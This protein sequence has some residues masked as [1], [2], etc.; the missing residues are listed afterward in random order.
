[1]KLLSI[2][3]VSL[4][5]CEVSQAANTTKLVHRTVRL[6]APS[7]SGDGGIYAS[8]F[9]ID[10]ETI[11]TAGH[12]CEA[13]QESSGKISEK[14]QVNFINANDEISVLDGG[15]I[16]RY[17][18]SETVDLCLI[19]LPRHGIVPVKIANY[20]KV[21]VGDKVT[22]VGAPMGLGYPNITEGYVTQK[23]SEGFPSPIL[24]DKLLTS[25]PVFAGNSGGPVFNE[26]GEVIGVLVMATTKYEHLSFSISAD[27]I[28]IWLE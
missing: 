16:S 7:L 15:V 1:M 19:K 27:V 25:A 24:N 12:F 9:P 20:E 3:L 11:M 17:E 10:K 22:I 4:F 28:K 2:L 18:F 23:H 8:G 6:F 14:I 13:V 26:S 21:R 5:F